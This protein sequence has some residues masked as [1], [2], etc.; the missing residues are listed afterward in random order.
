MLFFAK[1]WVNHGE[2]L[3]AAAADVQVVALAM[4]LVHDGGLF[5]DRIG[6]FWRVCIHSVIVLRL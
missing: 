6:L 2:G 1:V 3:G 4:H 5:C